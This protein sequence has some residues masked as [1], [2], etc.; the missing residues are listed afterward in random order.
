MEWAF[1]VKSQSIK[2]DEVFT[3]ADL[4]IPSSF[5]HQVFYKISSP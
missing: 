1:I 4:L 2:S 3:A 5:L